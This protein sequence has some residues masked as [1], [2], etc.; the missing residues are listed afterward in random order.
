MYVDPAT[1]WLFTELVQQSCIK[2]ISN[3]ARPPISSGEYI[4]V[5]YFL[6]AVLFPLYHTN[7]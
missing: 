2:N 7:T 5:I 3:P 1:M 4:I 6:T